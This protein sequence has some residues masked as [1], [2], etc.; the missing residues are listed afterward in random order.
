MSGA[1][2]LVATAVGSGVNVCFANPGT[3]EVTLMH[4]MDRAPDMRPVLCLS[5]GVC[6]GAADGYGRMRDLPALTLTHLGP[7]IANA[8]SNLHNAR[9]AR[10]P[11]VNVV[12]DH[13]RWHGVHDTPLSMDVAALAGTVGTWVRKTE[14]AHVVGADMRAAIEHAGVG[15]GQIATLIVSADA[16]W[17]PGGRAEVAQRMRTLRAPD[18]QRVQA[19]A[20]A[21]GRTPA[22]ALLLAG[23]AL[24]ERPLRLAQAIALRAGCTLMAETFPARMER[25]RGLPRAVRIPYFPEQARSFLRGFRDLV[26]V[27]GDPPLATFGYRGDRS[28]LVSESTTVSVLADPQED[29]EEALAAL[30]ELLPP[31]SSRVLVPERAV[32]PPRGALNPQA[33][34]AAIASTQPEG[35]IVVDE[36]ATSG[37][38]YVTLADDAPPFTQLSLTGGAIGFGLPCAVGAAIAC[39]DRRVIVFQADGGALYWPQ[40]LWTAA[41]ASLNVTVVVCANRTYRILQVESGRAG[42]GTSAGPATAA[43]TELSPPT[44]EFVALARAFGIEATRVGSA[45]ELTAALAASVNTPGPRLIEVPL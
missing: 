34:A 25:G 5:E 33:I 23:R 14:G 32:A 44:V 15:P 40:A 39:P 12:G 4:A 11:V 36:S 31:G 16:Q 7:G 1:D 38:A 21:L 29:V 26:I 45:E 22:G 35:A 17:D 18:V 27:G 13:A 37:G 2:A 8:L 28:D 41:R 19:A 6:S 30:L 10:S 42:S 20:R 43:L 24:R 3:T 9:K